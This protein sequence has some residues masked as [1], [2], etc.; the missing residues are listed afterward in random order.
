MALLL[1]Y[2]RLLMQFERFKSIGSGKY[3]PIYFQ[4]FT[5]L[6]D[7]D[8]A[9]RITSLTYIADQGLLSDTQ[10]EGHWMTVM[11]C[12]GFKSRMGSSIFD[13]HIYSNC[14]LHS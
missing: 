3:S 4:A 1:D 6:G 12:L 5:Q 11:G 2:S 7:L 14:G 8:S 9:T 10:L 13:W